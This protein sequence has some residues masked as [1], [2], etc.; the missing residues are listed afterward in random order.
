MTEYKNGIKELGT[1]DGV[2]ALS[3]IS[4]LRTRAVLQTLLSFPSAM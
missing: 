3:N 2:R 1:L 4:I